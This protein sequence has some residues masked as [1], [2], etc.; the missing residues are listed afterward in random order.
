MRPNCRTRDWIRSDVAQVATTATVAANH[1][2]AVQL[3]EVYEDFMSFHRYVNFKYQPLLAM[4][5][6][7]G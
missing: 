4:R 6:V 1:S 2:F 5:L 7:F 3:H